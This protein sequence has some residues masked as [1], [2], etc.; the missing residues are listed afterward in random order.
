MTLT[1]KGRVQA[2]RIVIDEPLDLPE[3]SEIELMVVDPG[4]DLDDD[5]RQRLHATL[6]MAQEEVER[7]EGIAAE[8]LMGSLRRQQS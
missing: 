3:G 1:L 5:E 6:L 7:G 2:G 4:D 8:R